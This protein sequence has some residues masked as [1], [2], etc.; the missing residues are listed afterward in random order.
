MRSKETCAGKEAHAAL[1]GI[2]R[3]A[4]DELR[5]TGEMPD[6]FDQNCLESREQD[7][8]SVG[9]FEIPGVGETIVGGWL[10]PKPE[11]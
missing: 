8:A 1:I 10:D 4:I 7:A 5:R 2:A 6:Q 3:D 9:G 11:V